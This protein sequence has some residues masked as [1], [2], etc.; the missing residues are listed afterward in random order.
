M[1]KNIGY[2]PLI[3]ISVLMSFCIYKVI[4][5]NVIFSY[6][7][8]LRI[9][10]IIFSIATLFFKKIISKLITLSILI[11]ST[12]SF[13]AF[14]PIIEYRRIGFSIG[15]FGIDIKIQSYCLLL[16]LLFIFLNLDFLKQFFK[17]SS[18]L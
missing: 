7:H 9:F 5:S 12:F 13:A 2:L 16:L 4:T 15:D 1:K 14:T 8:Y 6:E 17:E 18:N 11:L 3:I 10:A